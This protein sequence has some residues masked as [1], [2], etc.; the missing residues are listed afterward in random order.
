MKES[1]CK[2][3]APSCASP[4]H[5]APGARHQKIH[6]T[7][8]RMTRRNH[9]TFATITTHLPQKKYQALLQ[10]LG[11]PSLCLNS[12]AVNNARSSLSLLTTAALK[13]D[14]EAVR[15][16]L[17]Y[18]GKVS[19][20]PAQFGVLTMPLHGAAIAGHTEIVKVSHLQ[21]TATHC[22]TLQ[23]TAAHCSTLQHTAAHC[24][25]LQHTATHCH[26]LQ[27]TWCLVR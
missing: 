22:N 3:D 11:T 18:G 10:E 8:V 1:W 24:S 2:N 19:G 14:V 7:L 13:G 17:K 6:M 12:D 9:H 16:V 5:R 27:H 21:H 20:A 26:T 15:L 4:C 25:T 23:H